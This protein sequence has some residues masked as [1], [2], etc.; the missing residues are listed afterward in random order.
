MDLAQCMSLG[1][2]ALG[3]DVTRLSKHLDM[4]CIQAQGRMTLGSPCWYDN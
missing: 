3:Y 1:N 2:N 4:I